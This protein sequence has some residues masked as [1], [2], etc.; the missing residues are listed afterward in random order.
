MAR[1]Y[2]NSYRGLLLASALSAVPAAVLAQTPSAPDDGVQLGEIVVTAQRKAERLQDVPVSVTA[3]TGETL[4]KQ[5]IDSASDLASVVPNLQTVGVVGEATPI[6]SLRG[7]SMSDY[8]LNQS[9]PV[10]TYFDEVYKGNFA[11]LG[12]PL[13]D[14][15]RIEVLRG[16]Q[17][18]LYGKNTTGGAV[19]LI[20]RKPGFSTG[21]ELTLGA[22]SDNRRE[23]S[24][25]FQTP[26]GESVAV[27]GAF[28]LSQADGWFRNRS[29]GRENLDAV[30]DF[31]ARLSILA[32]PT[33]GLE[34][35]LR[36][37][38]SR[39]SSANY[40]ILAQ[41]G[42]SGI[43]GGVYALFHS[44]DP[45]ANPRTDDY[46]IGLGPRELTSDFTPRR[47]GRTW[48]AALTSTWRL[49]EDRSIVSVTSWDRS[50][51][52]SEEDTDGSELRALSILYGDAAR[53][54]TQ[55]IRLTTDG[56]LSYTVGAFFGRETVFNATTLQAYQDID[57]NLDGVL[58]YQDCLTAGPPAGCQERNSFTQRK[59]SWAV[60]ADAAYAVADRWKLRGGLRYSVDRGRQDAIR[61]LLLGNDGVVLANLIPG[62][63][64][65]LD[66]T[67]SRRFSTSSVTG[68]LGIDYRLDAGLIYL[69]YSRGYRAGAFNAQAFFAPSELTVARPETVDALEAGFKLQ[70]SGRRLWVDGAVFGYR[71][72]DQQFIDVN[73]DGTQRLLNLPRARILGAELSFNARPGGGLTLSGG[74]GLLSTRIDEGMVQ[75]VSV[76]GNRLPN[77][78][79]LSANWAVDWVAP[80][81]PWGQ[82]EA[83][84]DGSYVSGQAFDTLN[85]PATNEGAYGL[86]NGQLILR[87]PDQRLTL[88]A[89]GRNLTD[90][91]Y[92]TSRIDI[93][94]FD[95]VYNHLGPPR[96]Y[97]VTLTYRY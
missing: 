53:Q 27:R 52:T 12:A 17:G 87:S 20:A 51:L 43:G 89:W 9:S 67:T 85:N 13:Y 33:D 16:P 61:S 21:G 36:L 83:R 78:P 77:A 29:P 32:R 55:D 3:I 90:R 2:R 18:T 35:V 25:A 88:E 37:A 15:E 19:N 45:V 7:V 92:R 10:A 96:T 24:G 65:D 57:F 11:L 69:S 49:S 30:G 6:F 54:F 31:G 76:R 91:T 5:K 41:P 38:T 22:G 71:Y 48:S 46:R 47:R 40:G 23:A 70:S 34:F 1:I 14:L 62:D 95:F 82:F 44:L 60:Y 8:S 64:L 59:T 4:Q 58:D 80:D 28:T 93:S 42:P 94:A 72:R 97:G 39:Q 66:A 74:L 68:K 86:L 26:L 50:R 84:L 75:G 63:P 79:R 73:P 56:P 81:Q